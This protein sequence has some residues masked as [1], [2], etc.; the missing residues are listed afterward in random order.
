MT[1]CAKIDNNT[2]DLTNAD[3]LV[4]YIYE[5]YWADD[6]IFDRFVPDQCIQAHFTDEICWRFAVTSGKPC[7]LTK[8]IGEYH[9]HIGMSGFLRSFGV[10]VKVLGWT[11]SSIVTRED[12]SANI[13]L[14]AKY[15]IRE[16][17]DTFAA[18]EKHVL[19][20]KRKSGSEELQIA[21]VAVDIVEMTKIVVT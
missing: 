5:E 9:G 18:R 3:D 16:S 10:V 7:A 21:R 19:H 1:A 2:N 12:L 8:L 13:E 6:L 4:R 17:G 11:P 14:N 15:Q 20:L